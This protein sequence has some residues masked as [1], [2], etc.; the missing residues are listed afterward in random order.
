MS[1]TNRENEVIIESLTD[2]VTE[3][4]DKITIL[5]ESKDEL[6]DKVTI[7]EASNDEWKD[8]F[9]LLLRNLAKDEGLQCGKIA[10]LSG[11]SNMDI[12]ELIGYDW[13]EG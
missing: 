1:N 4:K 2:Q 5:E 7:L 8:K 6:K 10:K 12:Y 3:L 9:V 11:C 13:F